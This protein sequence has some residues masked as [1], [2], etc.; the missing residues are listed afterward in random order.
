MVRSFSLAF[1][2]CKTMSVKLPP[3]LVL[4]IVCRLDYS[5]FSKILCHTYNLQV[6][7]VNREPLRVCWSFHFQMTS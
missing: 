3:E 7:V 2:F 6:D 5:C 4:E 1:L